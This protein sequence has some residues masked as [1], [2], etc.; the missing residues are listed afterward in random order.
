MISIVSMIS[1]IFLE[2]L[3]NYAKNASSITYSL[4]KKISPIDYENAI[5]DGIG[6][7]HEASVNLLVRK[8]INFLVRMQNH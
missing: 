2:E 7:I 8:L 4:N 5:E 3:G 1:S 6:L